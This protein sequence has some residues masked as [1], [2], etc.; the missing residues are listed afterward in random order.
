M[1]K[2]ILT[3][4]ASK[5]Q[6][7]KLEELSP[8]TGADGLSETAAQKHASFDGSQKS[9]GQCSNLER[10]R[11]NTFSMVYLVNSV[12]VG[13]LDMLERNNFKL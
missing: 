4:V 3:V 10:R 5:Q 11:T 1:F 8:S 6:W 7:H 2:D 13:H 9:N 12:T